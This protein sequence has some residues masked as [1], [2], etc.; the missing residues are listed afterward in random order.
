MKGSKLHK[1]AAGSHPYSSDRPIQSKKDDVLG[2]AKFA[3]R[4]A[5]DIYSWEGNDSLVIAL[6]GAWG[7][8]KT[9]VK[10]MLLE[11]N[12]RRRKKGLPVVEF[13]PWQLSGTGSIPISFFRELGVALKEEGPKRDVGKRAKKWNAYATT[14][15]VAGTATEWLG[16]ALPLAGVPGGP[17]IESIASGIKSVGA[18]AKEGGEALKAKSEAEAI[19]LEDQKRELAALLA[20]LPQPLLVVIDDI[21]RLTSDEILQV[22]QL[23]KANADFPR[24]TYLLLFE[25][26]VVAKALNRISDDKGMEFL[27]KIVQVGYH[28]P[29]ASQA[30]VQRVLF[31]GLDKHLGKITDSKRWDKNSWRNLYVDGVAGYFRHLRHVYRFL[32]SFAF[33]FRHHRNKESI[34]VNAVDLIGLEVRRVFEPSVYEKLP[35]GKTILTRY[36]GPSVFGEIKQETIDQAFSQIVSAAAPQNQNRVRSILNELFPPLLPAYAGK[37]GVSGHHQQWFRE[38]RICHPDLFDRYF[39]LTIADDD[40]SQAELD[41]LLKVTSDT[42]DFV[43]TCEALRNRGL[44]DLAFERLDAYKD[45]LPMESMPSLIVALCNMSDSFPE[46]GPRSFSQIFEHDLNAYAWRLCYFGLKREPDPKKRCEI[47][48]DALSRSTGLALPFELVSNDERVGDREAQ[49][50]EFLIA[51]HDLGTLKML[52]ME[53]FREAAKNQKLRG[54]QH[55]RSILLTW[56]AW[57]SPNQVKALIKDLIRTSADALWLLTILLGESHSYGQEHRVRYSMTLASIE[58]FTEISHLNN[59]LDGL[60]TGNLSKRETIAFRE[61]NKAMKRRAEGKPDNVGDARND[62]D[63]EV[64]E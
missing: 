49:G 42:K 32:A 50:R 54:N 1:Q 41:I 3:A 60:K 34:E 12:R 45:Q 22:F 6:Y 16:K 56:S 8:G 20:R 24:L 43:S 30:A 48:S 64:L 52:C 40:L 62:P 63:E 61:F 36:E 4:L 10:N 26:E 35:G 14:L 2:R 33:H 46:R 7:S 11:A 28:V 55:V 21:D 53:K 17:L 37:A 5:E 38:L 9:S 57:E 13:N 25:R 47:L 44:L 23:V 19:S 29:H 39:T 18:S 58:R 31:A 59:L 27:E 51:Q 15:A